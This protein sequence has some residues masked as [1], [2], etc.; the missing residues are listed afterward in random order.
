MAKLN[1]VEPPRDERKLGEVT[2][3]YQSHDGRFV[4]GSDPW[5]FETKWGK[6][7]ARSVYLLNDPPGIEGVAIAEGVTTI[8]QITPSAV[9]SADFTSRHRMPGVGQVA[10]LK[11]TEGFYAAVELLDVGYSNL[12]SQ[13]ILRMRFA[14]LTDRSNDF[15]PFA[16]DFGNQQALIGELLAA[17]VDAERALAKVQVGKEEEAAEKVGIGH[18]NPPSEFAIS[19]RDRAEM[20]TTIAQ[21][22]NEVAKA[23]PSSNILLAG[24]QAIFRLIGKVARWIGGKTD[25]AAE[26]F[27]KTAGKASGNFVF[28]GIPTLLLLQQSL[29][30][31]FEL[32]VQFVG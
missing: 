14:I 28:Y 7:S 2:F 29:T 25:I 13:N 21:I 16:G 15:S 26:E 6:A 1:H 4:I 32:L 22:R 18:N 20:L 27:A 12:P 9:A 19:E 30:K 8:S 23:E 3:N 24:G 5:A 10:L 17:A 11:N 31:L